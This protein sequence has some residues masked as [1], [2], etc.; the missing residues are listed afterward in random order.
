MWGRYLLGRLACVRVIFWCVSVMAVSGA[1]RMLSVWCWWHLWGSCFPTWLCQ[2][3]PHGWTL[4][5]RAGSLKAAN[6]LG[7]S[8]LRSPH[9]T[10]PGWVGGMQVWVGSGRFASEIVCGRS[11]A[12][13]L[14][15]LL[16]FIANYVG[17]LWL[18]VFVRWCSWAA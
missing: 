5:L 2:L 13:L 15:I 12:G 8:P 10:H 4:P 18:P 6:P 14:F 3:G 11:R 1:V 17:R 16:I 9:M 7:F